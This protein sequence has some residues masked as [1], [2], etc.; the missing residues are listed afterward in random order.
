MGLATL[1]VPSSYMISGY[2]VGQP[3]SPE[4]AELF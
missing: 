2:Y 3:S 1:E 4:Y